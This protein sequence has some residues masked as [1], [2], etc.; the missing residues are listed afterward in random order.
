MTLGTPGVKDGVVT[1][2]RPCLQCGYSLIGLSATGKCPE[3]GGDVARS[4]QG[5]LLIY[6]SVDFVSRLSGGATCIV[7]GLILFCMWGAC[8]VV[9]GS[10]FRIEPGFRLVVSLFSIGASILSLTGW[11]FLSS[12]DPALMGQDK[13]T[14]AR[15]ILRITLIVSIVAFGVGL[16]SQWGLDGSFFRSRSASI[17]GSASSLLWLSTVVSL[18]NWPVKTIASL[19]YTRSL[20]LR[21]PSPVLEARA[22]RL[23][24][25]AIG[26][27]VAA[28][29]IIAVFT[30]L[31]ATRVTN[32]AGY[33]F[34]AFLPLCAGFVG[35]LI[36]SIVYATLV[37]GLRGDLLRV[38]KAQ[39]SLSTATPP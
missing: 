38:A 15:K 18:V 39:A 24:Q 36:W 21:I 14:G 20:A 31:L 7:A 23:I 19:Q 2:P 22:K 25:F 29:L 34:L 17:F 11:W 28:L 8:M 26:G 30:A 12:P 35:I 3:C 10:S 16:F 33:E 5:N 37:G 6:S 9:G 27:A 32:G 1:D 4:L 13:A